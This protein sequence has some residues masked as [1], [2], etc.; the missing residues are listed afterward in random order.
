MK[1]ELSRHSG[2]DT[3]KLQGRRNSRSET[4]NTYT[5]IWWENLKDSKA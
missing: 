4:T 1:E 3:E 2:E 5:R